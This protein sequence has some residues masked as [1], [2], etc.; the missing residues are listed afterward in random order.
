MTT[1]QKYLFAACAG[2]FLFAGLT[3]SFVLGRR[4]APGP[5]DLPVQVKTD[6]LIVRDTIREK[7]PVPVQSTPKG[8]ELVKA[9]TLADLRAHISALEA[10]AA[11]DT[12]EVQIP[13]EIESREYGGKEGDDYRAVVSGF[14]PSLDLIEVYPKTVYL[15]TEI[16]QPPDTRRKTRLGVGVTAG[17]GVYW[18][19][20]TIQPGIGATVGLSITF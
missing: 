8:Y 20:T 10:A 1:F 4:S 2:F 17:P 3:V 7:Y 15:Q 19:G 14:R 5:S 9:G 12:V 18:N 11:P 6:T 13:V 16:S